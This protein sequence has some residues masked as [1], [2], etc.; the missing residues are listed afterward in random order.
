MLITNFSNKQLEFYEE[1]IKIYK[2][3]S[4]SNRLRIEK[5][6]YCS[7]NYLLENHSALHDTGFEDLSCFWSILDSLRGR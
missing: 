7:N 5:K 4:G 3:Q 6:A 1:A 2:K